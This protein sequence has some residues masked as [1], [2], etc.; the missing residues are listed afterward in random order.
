M[1]EVCKICKR[2][3]QRRL[4]AMAE[5]GQPMTNPPPR[6]ILLSE[7]EVRNSEGEV[8]PNESQRAL[9]KEEAYYG[10]MDIK[11]VWYVASGDDHSALRFAL[12]GLAGLAEISPYHGWEGGPDAN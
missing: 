6:F 7:Q 8:D 5:S 10:E 9:E 11:P 2:H 1:R 4:K 12:E 3:Q